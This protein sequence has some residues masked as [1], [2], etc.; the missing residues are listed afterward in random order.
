M[1][2]VSDTL[3]NS[4]TESSL[5]LVTVYIT[6]HN[7]GRYLEQAIHSVLNQTFRNYE[8]LIIDDGSDDHSKEI[9]QPYEVDTRVTVIFQTR[10]GLAVSNNIAL[11]MARGIYIMRLDADDYLDENALSV[12]VGV[13]ERN[14]LADMV[15]PDYYLVDEEGNI[16][17]MMRRHQFEDVDLLDQPAHG[18]CTLIRK[19]RLIELGGY[20]E[21]FQCQDGYDLWLRFTRHYHVK[22]VNLPMFYYR[23]HGK[24]LTGDEGRILKTRNQILK[25]HATLGKNR[26]DVAAIIPVRGGNLDP[27][28]L[29]MKRLCGKPLISYTIEAALSSER[30]SR[31]LVTTPNRDIVDFVNKTYGSA[32]FTLIR[33]PRL[34]RFNTPIVDTLFHA[35]DHLKTLRAIPDAFSLLYIESP[36]RTHLDINAAINVMEVFDTDIVVGVRPDDGQFYQHNGRGLVAIRKNQLLRLEREDMFREAGQVRIVRRLFFEKYKQIHQ[37]KMGHLVVDQ[38]SSLKIKSDLDWMF[39]E[40]AASNLFSAGEARSCGAS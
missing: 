23:K 2:K 25:K 11:K 29:A 31:V 7:Y 14:P 24:N 21:A 33:D 27:D 8:L 3:N 26:L 19:E 6:N 34:A 39:A 15:F 18:A 9:L 1:N 35:L 30:I 5:P 16:L 22:N 20:D 10:K 12:M 13:I 38:L 37:G 36:F 32:V 4:M 40:M 17:E 28:S